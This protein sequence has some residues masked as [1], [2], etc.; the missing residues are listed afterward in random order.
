L[1]FQPIIDSRSG[2]VVRAEALVRWHHPTKGWISRRKS[3]SAL[4]R[5]RV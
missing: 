5:S 2:E 4:R 3:L 1:E